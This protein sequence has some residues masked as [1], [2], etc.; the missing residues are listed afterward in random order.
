MIELCQSVKDVITGYEGIV[1]SRHEYFYGCARYVVQSREMKDGVP[2]AEQIFDERRLR[3]L[4]VPN[5][6][7]AVH[8]P[9]D[10]GSDHPEPRWRPWY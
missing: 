2:V 9:S 3:V 7:E 10:P 5:I 8:P 1:V 4:D 6:L